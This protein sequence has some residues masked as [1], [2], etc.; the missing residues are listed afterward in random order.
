MENLQISLVII[1]QLQS[2]L[3]LCHESIVCL[4]MAIGRSEIL[5]G[6]AIIAIQGPKIWGGTAVLF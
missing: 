1:N 6:H 2:V 5:G 4:P 3:S